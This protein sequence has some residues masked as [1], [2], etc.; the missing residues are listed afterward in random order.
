[1]FLEI[2]KMVLY[3]LFT[4]HDARHRG[5]ERGDENFWKVFPLRLNSIL[6][7]VVSRAREQVSLI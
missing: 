1:M 2:Y 7:L 4:M 3:S 6:P 5:F